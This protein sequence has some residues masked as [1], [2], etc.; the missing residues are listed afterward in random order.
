MGAAGKNSPAVA[1]NAPEAA[2]EVVGMAA[3]G[4]KGYTP[5]AAR[6]LVP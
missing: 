6:N 1:D 3:A 5:R 2:E 4:A